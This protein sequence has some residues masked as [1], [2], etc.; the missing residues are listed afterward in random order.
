MFLEN[1]YTKWY[2][3]LINRANNRSID[4]NQ[5][6]EL[7]HI[8]PRSLGGS[9]FKSNL[10]RFTARE[11]YI[12]HMLLVRM[13]IGTEKTKMQSAVWLMLHANSYQKRYMPSN[14]FYEII[15]RDMAQASSE[16]N[17]G[18]SWA[19]KMGSERAEEILQEYKNGIRVPW[20]KGQTNVM[21]KEAKDK[22]AE[23]RRNMH[24]DPYNPL[25][26]EIKLKI[27]LGVKRAK[28]SNPNSSKSPRPRIKFIL[29][30]VTTNEKQ[31]T[32]NLKKWAIEQNTNT[33]Q[34]YADRS[35]WKIIEKYSLKTGERIS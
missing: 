35:P 32:T 34:I 13:T 31:E 33:V 22:I 4:N 23:A 8:I 14:R 9:N 17:K 12:A 16:H 19:E 26:Q 3:Q 28:L 2:Y 27:S 7:H 11:H 15:K 18:K 21:S 5:Y 24:L 25:T 10:V 30:N 20:N 6:Y 29:L 1:I